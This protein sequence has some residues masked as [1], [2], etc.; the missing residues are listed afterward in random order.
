MTDRT[1]ERDFKPTND[2]GIDLSTC[3]RYKP[4][5]ESTYVFAE[6]KFDSKRDIYT[7]NM[8]N[9]VNR[10]DLVSFEAPTWEGLK[11]K[12]KENVDEYYTWLHFL[13]DDSPTS[14]NEAYEAKT[15]C[16][17]SLE[18]IDITIAHSNT[19]KNNTKLGFLKKET[20]KDYVSEIQK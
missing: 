13:T 19:N 2:Y 3:F 6:V 20:E 7:G 4:E 5:N 10:D 9:F 16:N 1:V 12:F 15:A 18:S 8:I 17:D 11:K 14:V